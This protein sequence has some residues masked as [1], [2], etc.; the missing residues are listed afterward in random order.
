MCFQIR[1]DVVNRGRTIT[2]TSNARI[3]STPATFFGRKA[4]VEVYGYGINW[5]MRVDILDRI[6]NIVSSLFLEDEQVRKLVTVSLEPMHVLV[7]Y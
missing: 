1:V 5:G 3:L 2:V 7:V 4:N 6:S